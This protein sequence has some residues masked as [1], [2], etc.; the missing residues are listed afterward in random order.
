MAR[1]NVS[2]T[3]KIEVEV[4]SVEE[5]LEAVEAGVDIILLDNMVPQEISKVITILRE[6]QLRKGVFLEAS[7][8]IK[9][10]NIRMYS[11][12]G[13][14]AISLGTITH[15]AKNIDFGLEIV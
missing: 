11:E 14:D 5:A 1:K 8:G 15:S 2:F 12:T 7:G 10:E 4:S 9:I 13:V 6:K 3:K